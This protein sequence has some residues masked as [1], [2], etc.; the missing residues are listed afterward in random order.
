MGRC[1]LIYF[2]ISLLVLC[3][4]GHNNLLYMY[5]MDFQ[6]FTKEGILTK[7][8]VFSDGVDQLL[9]ELRLAFRGEA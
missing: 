2:P 5:E 6:S 7:Q 4:L 1:H 8:G 9:L 3:Y